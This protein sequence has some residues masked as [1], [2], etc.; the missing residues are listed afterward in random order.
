MHEH[1]T[2]D[3]SRIKGDQ[4]TNLDCFDETVNEFKKLYEYGV[5][6]ILDV[7]NHGMGRNLEYVKKVENVTGIRILQS[8]CD[9]TKN[10]ICQIL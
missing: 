9:V 10:H 6:N 5:R 3:L 8:N 2:V 1:T 4:D 7:T